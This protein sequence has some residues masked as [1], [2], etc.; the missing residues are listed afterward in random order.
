MADSADSRDSSGI[1]T[2]NIVRATWLTAF[3][4]AIK[5]G[6]P[7]IC[8]PYKRVALY[9]MVWKA[10]RNPSFQCP[11]QQKTH[12]S[13]WLSVCVWPCGHLSQWVP[14]IPAHQSLDKVLKFTRTGQDFQPVQLPQRDW[15]VQ[16]VIGCVNLLRTGSDI[17]PGS[18]S[19]AD[20]PVRPV[21]HWEAYPWT[22]LTDW[23]STYY[24]YYTSSTTLCS[25][26]NR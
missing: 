3:K 7:N 23:V 17:W 11:D 10:W 2:C 13:V 1:E 5:R 6:W 22:R 21:I 12:R 24:N 9:L 15:P 20:R 25:R 8:M 19:W 26:N 18:T 4:R 14:A 16:P